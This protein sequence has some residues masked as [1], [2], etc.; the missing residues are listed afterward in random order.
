M[1]FK[2]TKVETVD[3]LVVMFF[4]LKGGVQVQRLESLAM[5]VKRA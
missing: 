1:N 3:N 2:Q 4:S 5:R